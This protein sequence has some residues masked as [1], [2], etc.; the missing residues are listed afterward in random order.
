METMVRYLRKELGM[1][2]KELA[3][4]AGVSR[5]T[6]NSLEN[7]KYNPSLFLAIKISRLLGCTFIEEVFLIE[8]EDLI[9]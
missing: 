8:D 5:Q 2:Q 9:D 3:K 7:G 4:L 1:S 6:I